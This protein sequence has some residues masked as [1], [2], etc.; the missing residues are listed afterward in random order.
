M[1]PAVEQRFVAVGDY[2]QWNLDKFEALFTLIT[3]GS[4]YHPLQ[5]K[6]TLERSIE[7]TRST[8]Q[9]TYELPRSF[10]SVSDFPFL[11][12]PYKGGFRKFPFSRIGLE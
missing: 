9:G 6:V 2:Y 3:Q 5:R 11:R 4:P 12:N 1:A 8:N 10:A 7:V